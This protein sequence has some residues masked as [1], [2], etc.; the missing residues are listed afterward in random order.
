VSYGLPE[1][2]Q[3]APAEMA[4][5]VAAAEALTQTVE[6]L[7]QTLETPAWRFSGRWFAGG[8]YSSLRRPNY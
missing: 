6:V 3:L 1:R 8:R 2:P 4:A 5:V 7:G